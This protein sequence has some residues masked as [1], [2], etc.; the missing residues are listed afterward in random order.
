MKLCTKCKLEKPESEFNLK[1]KE[2]G[3]R[4]SAC[5]ICTR[6]QVRKHYSENKSYYLSKTKERNARTRLEIRKFI[7]RYLESH[8]C[9]DCGQNDPIV[10]EFDHQHSKKINVSHTTKNNYS[11]EKLMKEIDKC[12]VRCANCHRRK[13]ALELNWYKE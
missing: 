5:R 2:K 11:I 13:T 9:I 8:P 12:E 3:T 7:W 6:R 1:S 10:L 4:Q